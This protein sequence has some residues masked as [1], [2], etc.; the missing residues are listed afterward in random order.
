MQLSLGIRVDRRTDMHKRWQTNIS[1][2]TEN[3]FA[4]KIPIQAMLVAQSARN[5]QRGILN[6]SIIEGHVYVYIWGTHNFSRTYE[7]GM[8]KWQTY[9]VHIR[10]MQNSY[11]N[12]FQWKHTSWDVWVP[13]KDTYCKINR[14]KKFTLRY[15]RCLLKY[16]RLEVQ[17]AKRNRLLSMRENIGRIYNNG[18]SY[19]KGGNFWI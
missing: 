3:E 1:C 4:A 8:D 9:N 17:W 18:L 12:Q 14:H 10:D 7:H 16:L 15:W 2:S 13:G 6:S 11:F 5:L 19:C